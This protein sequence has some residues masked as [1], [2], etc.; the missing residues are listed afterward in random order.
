M[1]KYFFLPLILLT[2][3]LLLAAQSSTIADKNSE[4]FQLGDKTVVIPVP[5][6]FTDVT[7]L[8][9][10]DRNVFRR[11]DA[12]GE[13]MTYVRNE[14]V[15]Q[16]QADPTIS[17]GF[18]AM[19]WIPENRR[20]TDITA[21]YFAQV[22]SGMERNF[23]ASLDPK[24]KV[25]AEAKK[26]ATTF[27]QKNLDPNAS[28]DFNETKNLGF[29]DKSDH[30]FSAMAFL[31]AQTNGQT[32]TTLMTFSVLRLNQRL[33]WVYCYTGTPTEKDFETLPA[34]TRTWTA[35]IIAANT[36][37]TRLNKK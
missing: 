31:S 26:Q 10:N 1:M 8:I 14:I 33:V 20:T 6:G 24:S 12:D 3:P 34:F 16:L 37:L 19:G 7:G 5:V 29:I 22:V 30:V 15:S 21:E 25:M 35:A 2:L 11:F 28:I 32:K 13:N 9:K 27:A 4:V 18:Y 36:K 17:R 23:A